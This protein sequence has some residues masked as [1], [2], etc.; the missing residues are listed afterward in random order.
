[1]AQP[2]DEQAQPQ[3]GAQRSERDAD[4]AGNRSMLIPKDARPDARVVGAFDVEV[5]AGPQGARMLAVYL[6]NQGETLLLDFNDDEKSERVA[7]EI[8]PS[9][10]ER[11]AT[12]ARSSGL[13][14]PK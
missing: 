2:E 10:V 1:M 14:V 13:V 12:G 7:G 5:V 8:R 9:R 11:L 4:R 6:F 3:E